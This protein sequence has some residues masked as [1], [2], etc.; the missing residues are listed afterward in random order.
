MKT[1]R[2]FLPLLISK[3]FIFNTFVSATNTSSSGIMGNCC[4]N[5][6]LTKKEKITLNEKVQ[7]DNQNIDESE[8]SVELSV[9]KDSD[10]EY[11]SDNNRINFTAFKESSNLEEYK[12]ES[13]KNKLK[14]EQKKPSDE[15][16]TTSSPKVDKQYSNNSLDTL[17]K[18]NEHSYENT[19]YIKPEDSDYDLQHTKTTSRKLN[20]NNENLNNAQEISTEEENVV[21]SHKNSISSTNNSN[22]DNSSE[23]II[24]ENI[25]EQEETNSPKIENS[26]LTT[27]NVVADEQAE[28]EHYQ[29]SNNNDF[30]PKDELSSESKYTDEKLNGNNVVEQKLEQ[31]SEE[32]VK[33]KNTNS[34][35]YIVI[36]CAT[37]QNNTLDEEDYVHSPKSTHVINK[38]ELDSDASDDDNPVIEKLK[39]EESIS[40]IKSLVSRKT[41]HRKNLNTN[42]FN[43]VIDE[44]KSGSYSIS[45]KNHRI[46]T[47]H[48]EDSVVIRACKQAVNNNNTSECSYSDSEHGDIVS[49]EDDSKAYI[50]NQS[51][52]PTRRDSYYSQKNKKKSRKSFKEVMLDKNLTTTL[53]EPLIAK[54]SN[55][56][57]N[58]KI[59]KKPNNT[60]RV[61]NLNLDKDN[62]DI[63]KN[64]NGLNSS[65]NAIGQ[66]KSGSR[67]FSF[68]VSIFFG[69]GILVFLLLNSRKTT[70]LSKSQKISLEPQDK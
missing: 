62:F 34:N 24:N 41:Q 44:R 51:I 22:L 8:Q 53:A 42:E 54:E 40:N 48:T 65:Y 59:K 69:G 27:S 45:N 18:E 50:I 55:K 9:S 13:K 38:L 35:N 26:T 19:D 16:I 15:E 1:Y 4:R 2:H 6:N 14:T 3:I 20:L 32:K 5:N 58:Y 31:F 36:E 33:L 67:M 52:K 29:V 70:K 66:K 49:D 47:N 37:N 46:K 56:I 39:S 21:K 10:S 23:S 43:Q 17:D 7:M 61:I 11:N 60:L 30:A 63:N 68:I 12:Q 64:Y 57:N 28:I 25:S